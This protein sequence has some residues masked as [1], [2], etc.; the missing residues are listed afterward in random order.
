[1]PVSVCPRHARKCRLPAMA[2]TAPAGTRL[3]PSSTQQRRPGCD[4]PWRWRR[5]LSGRPGPAVWALPF[6]PGGPF[7]STWPCAGTPGCPPTAASHPGAGTS[8]K[9]WKQRPLQR[10]SEGL[11]WAPC[12][13][14]PSQLSG[15]VHGGLA[16]SVVF[17][18]LRCVAVCPVSDPREE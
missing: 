11:L 10:S 4:C 9:H 6:P 14:P 17:L 8:P 7:L 3:R 1:M 2:Q 12:S 16:T 15:S 5:R 13:M 18:V